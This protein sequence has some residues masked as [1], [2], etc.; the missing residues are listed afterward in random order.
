VDTDPKHWIAALR[1]SHDDLVSTVVDLRPEDLRTT[2]GS[3]DWD[4]SQVLAHLGSGAEIGLASMTAS[5]NGTEPPGADANQ[6]VWD[7]WNAMPATERATAFVAADERYVA[8]VEAI[9]DDTLATARIKLAF[10]PQPVDVAMALSFRLSE[11]SLHAWDVHVAFDPE[12]TVASDAALLLVDRQQLMAGFVGRPAAWAGPPVTVAVR[13]TDPERRFWLQLGDAVVLGSEER[14]G[15]GALSLPAE[16]L[17]R[18][19]AGRLT[20]GR[21]PAAVAIDGPVSLDDLRAVFPGY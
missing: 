12:A 17:V 1:H 11:H 16:S 10:L 13:T 20:P 18:L 15:A 2:S 3:R 14:P 9:D 4:V 5:L 7:R 19:I 8:A 21:T 6:P